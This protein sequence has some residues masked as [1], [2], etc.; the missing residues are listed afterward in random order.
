VAVG[1]HPRAPH[2]SVGKD[3]QRA[4]AMIGPSFANLANLSQNA[5]PPIPP[6]RPD[7]SDNAL[8][9]I[10][11]PV[12]VAGLKT[13]AAVEQVAELI[14]PLAG[15]NARAALVGRPAN[16][17]NV[18]INRA[19]CRSLVRVGGLC[20][21]TGVRIERNPF[22]VI[23]RCGTRH[24]RAGP[25]QPRGLCQRPALTRSRRTEGRGAPA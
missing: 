21:A 14:P 24:Y 13:A 2:V 12:V 17:H 8:W 16:N 1:E 5:S 9:E 22:R 19:I 23:L 3:V 6:R 18:R 20:R 15:M 7:N 25:P 4:E 10:G 11:P